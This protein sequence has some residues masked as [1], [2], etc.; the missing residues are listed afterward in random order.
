MAQGY[1]G[2]PPGPLSAYLG[3]EAAGRQQEM[4]ELQQVGAVQGLLAKMQKEQQQQQ[5]IQQLKSVMQQSGGSPEKAISA[6]LQHGTPNAI[7]LA[8]QLKGLVAKPD[9]KPMGAHGLYDPATGTT[10]PPPAVDPKVSESPLAK[11]WREKAALPPGDPRHADYVDAIKKA[12]THQP[13]V[14]VY[15]TNLTP[16]VN[17]RGEPV[18]V[19]PS[20]RPGVDPR[21]VPGIK[22]PPTPGERKDAAVAA[23]NELTIQNVRDRVNKMSALIQGNTAI[24]GPAGIARRIG[25]ATVGAIPGAGGIPTPALDYENEKNLMVA[26]IRKLIEKD[27]NLSNQERETLSRTLGGGTLQSPGS[28]IRTLS[29]VLNFIEGKK[30]SGPSRPVSPKIGEI[31]MGYRFKG[32]DPSKQENWDK[33]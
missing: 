3:V 11:L 31:K 5:E 28:A 25:E 29:N 27:P 19:Q 24:V 15:S 4:G 14:N 26:D 12:S 8:S 16:A 22:P 6:L 1:A 23:E 2:I 33:Q 18:F 10:I 13:A 17:E 32:G 20:G 7:H 30:L 21:V 9:L